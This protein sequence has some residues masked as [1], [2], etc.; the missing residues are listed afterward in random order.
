M[1]ILCEPINL[2]LLAH[3][4]LICPVIAYYSLRTV[5][6]YYFPHSLLPNP[7]LDILLALKR[8]RVGLTRFSVEMGD[9][10][11]NPPLHNPNATSESGA[12]CYHLQAHRYY[13]GSIFLAASR[14]FSWGSITHH[15]LLSRL[16]HAGCCH[17]R[18]RTL[19]YS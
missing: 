16:N 11:L 12:N 14:S 17:S 5:R 4:K 6:R 19:I 10:W 3:I 13:K 9:V 7:T 8:V 18:Q 1:R 15:R 2:V